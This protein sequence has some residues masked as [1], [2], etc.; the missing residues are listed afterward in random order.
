MNLTISLTLDGLVRA[1]RW[2]E[3][4]LAENVQR[5]YLPPGNADEA[6]D[7]EQPISRRSRMTREHHDDRSGG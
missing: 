3:H 5:R 2:R 4:D 7:I 1:L 6:D